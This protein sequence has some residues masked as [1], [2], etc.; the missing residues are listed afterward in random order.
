MAVSSPYINVADPRILY[1]FY[2]VYGLY[3]SK[4]F[5][6]SFFSVL[7][8]QPE[9][10]ERPPYPPMGG[11]RMLRG[12]MLRMEKIFWTRADV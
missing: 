11:S 12:L 3:V 10:V 1:I 4:V 2:V 9:P 6:F 5:Q 7:A 8:L